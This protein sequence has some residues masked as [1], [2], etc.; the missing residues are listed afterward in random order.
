[1]IRDEVGAVELPVHD[2]GSGISTE[3]QPKLFRAFTQI[4]S[5]STHRFEGTGLDLY[6]SQKLPDLIDGQLSFRSKV[7]EG[8]SFTLLLQGDTQ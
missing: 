6:L 3:D 2:T 4:D 5:S 8:S 1:M 7:G